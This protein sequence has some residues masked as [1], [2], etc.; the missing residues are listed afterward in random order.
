MASYTDGSGCCPGCGSKNTVEQ[1]FEKRGAFQMYQCGN[2]DPQTSKGCGSTWEETSLSAKERTGVGNINH[3]GA[4]K[5]GLMMPP[6]GDAW[7]RIFGPKEQ[8]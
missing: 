7:D 2:L 6:L 3:A 5:S 8:S 4:G 1:H